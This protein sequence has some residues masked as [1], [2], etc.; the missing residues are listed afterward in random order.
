MDIANV[1]VVLSIC[2]KLLYPVMMWSSTGLGKSTS[3]F[4]YCK[5]NFHFYETD[6]NGETVGLVPY[7]ICDLRA[8]QMESSDIR[9]LPA[10]DEITKSVVYYAPEE[11]PRIKYVNRNGEFS[12][13]EKDGFVPYK[14]VLFLDE[15]NRAEDDVLQALFQLIYDRCIGN[16]KLP[17]WWMIAGAG[18]PSN[19]NYNVNQFF[20]D[21]AMLDR[22]VHINLSVTDKYYDSWIG[23]IN[24]KHGFGNKFADRITQ[25]V[26]IDPDNFSRKEATDDLQISPTPRSWDR[27]INIETALEEFQG[28]INTTDLE[29]IRSELISGIVGLSAYQAYSSF[30][31]DITPRDIIENGMDKRNLDIFN[32]LL[33]TNGK[34]NKETNGVGVLQS[35]A[36]GVA[37][38]ARRTKNPSDKF[39]RNVLEFGKWL[40][41]DNFRDIGFG[42]FMSIC[43]DETSDSHVT[44]VMLLNPSLK[45]LM[46]QNKNKPWTTAIY[47]DPET[48]KVLEKIGQKKYE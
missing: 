44:S 28:K 24:D 48:A 39:M 8:S 36:F 21:A 25:F 5:N 43:K 22:W 37:N 14:G 11:L 31:L 35:V 32:K 7:G 15:P 47:N 26:R 18:N 12:D 1:P 29:Q 23:F 30:Q 45:K 40:C 46:T 19:Q 27:V 6:S 34:L 33:F 20:K 16:Y 10:K 2:H 3:V 13:V 38:H 41:R 9:G 17:P 4:D 42:Y